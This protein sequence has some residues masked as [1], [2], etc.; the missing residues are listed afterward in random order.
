MIKD[1]PMTE[2]EVSRL[3]TRF[4]EKLLVLSRNETKFCNARDLK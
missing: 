1:L 3:T 2:K 4:L